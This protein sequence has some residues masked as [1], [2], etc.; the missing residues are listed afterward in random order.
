MD[1]QLCELEGVRE[2]LLALLACHR[3][4]DLVAPPQTGL[5]GVAIT[6]TDQPVADVECAEG[7]KAAVRGMPPQG[8]RK[9]GDARV[10]SREPERR[11]E[12]PQGLVEQTAAE[13][14]R[15]QRPYRESFY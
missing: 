6:E 9:V 11:G 15:A 4:G 14:F 1:V 8:I 5:A 3:R 10:A 7:Q 2:P 12:D 13:L